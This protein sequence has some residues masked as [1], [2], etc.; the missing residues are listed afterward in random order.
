MGLVGI[1]G[2]DPEVEMT[3][4]APRRDLRSLLSWFQLTE[5]ETFWLAGI[6]A[7]FLVGLAVQAYRSGRPDPGT[8]K[9]PVQE[10]VLAPPDEAALPR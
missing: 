1:P 10:P 9:A 3:A 8:I 2:F 4:P 5:R 7:I 6:T